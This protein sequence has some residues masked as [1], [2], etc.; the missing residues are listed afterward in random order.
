VV[1]GAIQSIIEVLK[2]DGKLKDAPPAQT[3]LDMNYL[4]AIER[5]RQSGG[6]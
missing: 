4:Q 2:E 1:P 6:K 5:E 3:F